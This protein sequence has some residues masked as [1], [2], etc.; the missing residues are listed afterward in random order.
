MDLSGEEEYQTGGNERLIA[1]R[2]KIGAIEEY[3]KI[4]ED[5]DADS[6]KEVDVFN[7]I[8]KSYGL[9]VLTTIEEAKY[10]EKHAE[11]N[12]EHK[13]QML[14]DLDERAHALFSERSTILNI[15]IEPGTAP[16]E[17]IADM[18]SEVSLLYRKVGGTGISFL[19][20][21]ISITEKLA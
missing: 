3:I 6:G 2:R 18:L 15:K 21:N 5:T 12:I 17:A 14:K 7:K 8:R 1:E 20:G 9:D 19:P 13:L 10:R 11:K 4:I 16:P